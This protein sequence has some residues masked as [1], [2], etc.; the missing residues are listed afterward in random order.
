LY[1]PYPTC[2]GETPDSLYATENE[3]AWLGPCVAA[4]MPAAAVARTAFHREDAFPTDNVA[5]VYVLPDRALAWQVLAEFAELFARQEG[6]AEAET[7]LQRI[8]QQ[9][10]MGALQQI[11]NARRVEIGS[12]SVSGERALPQLDGTAVDI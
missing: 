6:I 8:L 11:S 4:A 1:V 7:Q 3:D 2:R 5:A 9:T 12:W 10:V